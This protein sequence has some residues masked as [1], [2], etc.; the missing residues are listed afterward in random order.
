[1][2]GGA[3]EEGLH[4]IVTMAAHD[5]HVDSAMADELGNRARGRPLQKVS[6]LKIDLMVIAQTVES[7]ALGRAHATVKAW[8]GHRAGAEVGDVGFGRVA[9]MQQV[10]FGVALQG[11]G[12]GAADDLFIQ[13]LACAMAVQIDRGGDLPGQGR[14][15]SLTRCTATGLS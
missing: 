1:M 14:R 12:M 2:G 5:D 3:A 6:T 15:M 8:H 9:H 10:Q 11:Q 13:M 4:R 7:G